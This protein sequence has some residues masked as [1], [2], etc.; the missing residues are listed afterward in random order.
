MS[1]L[2]TNLFSRFV[3][4]RTCLSPNNKMDY[5]QQL[6]APDA[7]QQSGGQLSSESP[8]VLPAAVRQTAPA[9]IV[10]TNSDGKEDRFKPA[11]ISSL[12]WKGFVCILHSALVVAGFPVIV[13]TYMIKVNMQVTQCPISILQ[14]AIHESP[15]KTTCNFCVWLGGRCCMKEE[16]L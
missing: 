10:F 15:S 16:A 11:S 4:A 3:Q 12:E 13:R 7:S 2:V 6:G 8:D 1:S 5:F 14:S 9:V